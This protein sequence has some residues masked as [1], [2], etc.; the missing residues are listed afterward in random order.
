VPEVY[1]PQRYL[2]NVH[3]LGLVDE[4]PVIPFLEDF[5][6]WGSDGVF[7]ENMVVSVESYIGELGGPDGIKLEEQV[8]ITERGA[9]SMS[10]SALHDALTVPD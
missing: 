1:A 4:Y 9:I 8:L 7:V 6:A 10:K 2:G 5:P 3:G